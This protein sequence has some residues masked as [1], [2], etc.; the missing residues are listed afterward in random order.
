[1]YD[2][3]QAIDS[4]H[5]SLKRSRLE[6]R[7]LKQEA[8]PRKQ[9][10]KVIERQLKVPTK[11]PNGGREE[12]QQSN[13]ALYYGTRVVASLYKLL[14]GLRREKEFCRIKIDFS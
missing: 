7:K 12:L 9:E 5:E 2:A 4:L 10:I 3:A 13:I 14:V 11:L 1:M 6:A 8:A